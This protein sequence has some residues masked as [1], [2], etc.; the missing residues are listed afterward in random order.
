[1]D[2]HMFMTHIVKEK[3][4][5]MHKRTHNFCL[6]IFLLVFVNVLMIGNLLGKCSENVEKPWQEYRELEQLIWE[7][8]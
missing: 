7:D 8:V 6:L 4:V 5:Y 3:R 2:K 1:L